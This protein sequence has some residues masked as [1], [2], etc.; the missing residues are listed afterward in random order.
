MRLDTNT[1]AKKSLETAPD[2]HWGKQGR[3]KS[4]WLETVKKDPE[5]VFIIDLKKNEKTIRKLMCATC[6]SKQ[7]RETAKYSIMS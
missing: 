3:P 1:P 4:T 7:W 6:G 5:P 2:E